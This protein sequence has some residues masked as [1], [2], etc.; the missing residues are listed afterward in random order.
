VTGPA[1][2]GAVASFLCALLG[3]SVGGVEEVGAG[4]WSKAFGFHHQGAEL[5]VRFSRFGDDFATDARAAGWARPELPIPEVHRVGEVDGVHYA[6]S[7]RCHGVSLDSLDAPGW[8]AVLPSLFATLDAMRGVD[9]AGH[10]GW[11]GLDAEGRGSHAAWRD[12]M[13]AA[14]DDT[15]ERRTHGWSE[16]LAR[17]PRAREAF[18]R[19][20]AR[21]EERTRGVSP[22]RSVVH[23]DLLE[24]N[25]LVRGDRIAAVLDWGCAH[26]GDFLY[27]VA[28]L[29]FWS[30]WH[31][32]LRS[33]DVRA[34]ARAHYARIGL[35]VPAFDARMDCAALHIGIDHLAYNA[36]TGNRD[37]L[38]GVVER[39]APWAG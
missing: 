9:V 39:L 28:W 5:I 12:F 23:G 16:R 17:E 8:R 27:D 33:L 20:Y 22:R 24:R 37:A 34:E 10:A 3:G 30:P 15:P 7:T 2:V 38:F 6:I 11:G 25:V 29:E 31:E 36:H 4:A 21:L 35:E 32:G 1:D 14:K 13:L 26:Y 18:A 19:A